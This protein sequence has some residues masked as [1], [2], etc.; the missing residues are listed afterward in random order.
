M[1]NTAKSPHQGI[2]KTKGEEQPA[3]KDR[4]QEAHRMRSDETSPSREEAG[5]KGKHASRSGHG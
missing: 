1:A 2:T 3:D 5:E 4:A